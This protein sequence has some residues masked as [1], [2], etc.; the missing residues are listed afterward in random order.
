MHMNVYL[1][2]DVLAVYSST[3]I[4]FGRSVIQRIMV[5]HALPRCTWA[6]SRKHV[7]M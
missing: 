1:Y 3:A 2:L 5:G 6:E 7:M 4:C